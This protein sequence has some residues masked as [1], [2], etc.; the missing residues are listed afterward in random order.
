M[1]SPKLRN[2]KRYG[3]DEDG[4][5]C[6]SVRNHESEVKK[7]IEFKM[8]SFSENKVETPAFG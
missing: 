2:G 6:G 1:S 4:Y 8:K 5:L 3:R 7:N